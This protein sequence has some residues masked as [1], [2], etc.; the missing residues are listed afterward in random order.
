MMPVRSLSLRP[1]LHSL[2][3]AALLP[4]LLPLLAYAGAEF[5][6][7]YSLNQAL[8]QIQQLLPDGGRFHYRELSADFDGRVALSGAE[9]WLPGMQQ[10][11]KFS[12]L[13]LKAEGWGELLEQADNIDQGVL[14]DSGQVS[15]SVDQTSLRQLALKPL[16]PGRYLRGWL[17]CVTPPTAGGLAAS[18]P[19][20]DLDGQLNY[21]FEPETHYLN[22]SLQLEGPKF[23]RV[24][25]EADLDIGYS[26]LSQQ[27]L[28]T[29]TVGLGGAKLALLN[30]GAQTAL[31]AECGAM[32]RSGLIQ[33]EYVARQ[34]R[35][36]RFGL[37]Q[38]G[39]QV[40]DTLELAYQD[41]LFLPVE[42]RLQWQA[43]QAVPLQR[44]TEAQGWADFT[45]RVGLNRFNS[46]R[47]D[48]GWREPESIANRGQQ[49]AEVEEVPLVAANE[50]PLTGLL[51]VQDLQAESTVSDT[52]AMLVSTPDPAPKP[53]YQP[54]YK[55][56]SIPQLKALL[57]SPLK[58]TT[59]NGRRIEGVL[60][61]VER[62]RLQLRREVAGGVAM[63]PVRLDSIE[64]LAAYF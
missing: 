6:L 3:K 16:N 15:F 32:G 7:R 43:R 30:R 5:Y 33:G 42:L 1:I 13:Q 26:R 62:N 21:R 57:G 12:R 39:W 63:V 37:E 28:S 20:A 60:D 49:R 53:S 24:E 55:R 10:P 41:Y 46:A 38:Q 17:G 18:A 64:Q 52:P 23:Y 25:L 8:V 61:S 2:K 22:L 4:L 29:Q 27:T 44:L 56:V 34:S 31:L 40:S 58:L 47:V 45:I 14:P 51:P 36:M 54:A 48:L 50:V 11:L 35:L 59:R 19:T 9:L